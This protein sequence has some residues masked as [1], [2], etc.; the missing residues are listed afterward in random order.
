M[1]ALS[2]AFAASGY[3]VP[4]NYADPHTAAKFWAAPRTLKLVRP[5]SGESLEAC[6]WRDGHLDRAGYLSICRLLRDVRANQAATID[7]RLLNLLR[8]MQG[9]LHSAYGITEPYQINSGFRTEHTN[10]TT[11]GSSKNSLHMDGKAVDGKFPSLP[12][13]Y[14]GKLQ[15]AFRGGGT[16]IYLNKYKFIHSDVGRVRQWR[17]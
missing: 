7:I 15:A 11:E 2:P 14:V 12:I 10:A 4:V 6:F 3:V 1:T 13:D 8:G 17:G 16:G 9:W 5:Q